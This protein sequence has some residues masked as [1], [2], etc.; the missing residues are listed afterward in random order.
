MK[1]EVPEN[2]KRHYFGCEKQLDLVTYHGCKRRCKNIDCRACWEQHLRA[3][4]ALD[5]AVENEKKAERF[6]TCSICGSKS[7]TGLA[8]D[9]FLCNDCGHYEF[10][11]ADYYK[12][13]M[14]NEYVTIDEQEL[15]ALL[16]QIK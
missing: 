7:I 2:L 9:R 3:D 10:C 14:G 16:K 12:E 1:Y 11:S 4:L 8:F 6:V 15:S 13:I 5:C